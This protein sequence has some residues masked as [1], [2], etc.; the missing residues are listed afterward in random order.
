MGR[1]GG[2]RKGG[3]KGGGGGG[4]GGREGGREEMTS[5]KALYFPA[6]TGNI[7]Y[8][9]NLYLIKPLSQLM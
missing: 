2:G 9:E 7:S 8:A 6:G 5:M 4:G 3:G 1:G